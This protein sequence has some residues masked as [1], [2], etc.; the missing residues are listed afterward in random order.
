MLRSLDTSPFLRAGSHTD[1][2]RRRERT[3][4]QEFS[5]RKGFNDD[6]VLFCVHILPLS[7]LVLSDCLQHSGAGLQCS[8]TLAFLFYSA[9]GAF[10][11]RRNAGADGF[12][13]A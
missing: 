3:G 4:S 13:L 5:A 1:E 6:V 2:R 12:V 8:P 7:F 11:P 9:P 10:S